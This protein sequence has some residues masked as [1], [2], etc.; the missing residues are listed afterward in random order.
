MLLSVLLAVEFGPDGTVIRRFTIFHVLIVEVLELF[1]L[2]DG[3]PVIVECGGDTVN[4]SSLGIS[5]R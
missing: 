5:S 2:L 4:S 1:P 3:R